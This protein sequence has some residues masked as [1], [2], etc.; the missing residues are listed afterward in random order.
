M[1]CCC[2]RIIFV[3]ASSS[4]QLRC[5][6][7]SH[8]IVSGCHHCCRSCHRVTTPSCWHIATMCHHHVVMSV[9][10]SA[11]CC[12]ATI[13]HHVTVTCCCI[14]VLHDHIWSERRTSSSWKGPCRSIIDKEQV[15]VEWWW[16]SGLWAIIVHTIALPAPVPPFSV[17]CVWR[18]PNMWVAPPPAARWPKH[19]QCHWHYQGH[20]KGPE[21][22]WY[23][24]P[25]GN[26][27]NTGMAGKLV[28]PHQCFWN[29]RPMLLFPAM[30][31]CSPWH[32]FFHCLVFGFPA[33]AV[34]PSN[35]NQIR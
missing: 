1:S 6:G 20:L 10:L 17:S 26:F 21:S 12:H 25:R 9:S 31:H 14:A 2:S 18:L 22:C 8:V 23:G 24:W 7:H 13:M 34:S 19:C 27:H 33:Q 3:V 16:S 15:G 30:G 28:V 35:L 11:S 29:P 4:L 32:P 5:H